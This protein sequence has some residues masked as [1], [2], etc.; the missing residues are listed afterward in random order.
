VQEN[1][2]NEP[3][4]QP[5]TLGSIPTP[6]P[7]PA[8]PPPPAYVAPTPVVGQPKRGF[9]SRIFRSVVL[10]ILILSLVLNG[11]LAILLAE[12]FSEQV[13]LS[14][15]KTQKIA[16][17]DLSGTIDML[18]AA[19]MRRMFKRAEKDEMVKGVI[20][21]VNCPGGQVAPSNMVNRYI[22]DFQRDTGKK[23]YV[24]IQQLGA[25]GAYWISAAA[26]K[27]YAQTNA[28]VGSIGVIYMSFVAENAL[29]EKLGI[30]PLILK[31]SRSPFK[32]RG[33]PF[34]QPSDAEKEKIRK[35]LD[36]VH[37]RFVQVVSEGRG[38]SED[39]AWALADGDVHDGPTALEKKL[40]DAIG[41]LEDVIDDL[42]GELGI[43]DPMV[44]R[45]VT[46]PSV[47]EMLFAQSP[48]SGGILGHVQSQLESWM[49]QPKIQ[50]LWTGK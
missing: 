48:P 5:I 11:Y 36:T 1:D 14:G 31:S 13:Y 28:I 22:Q 40:I 46:P 35:E 4:K 18:T 23:V 43:A 50:V 8:T 2:I 34:R 29:K 49:S 12:R 24:S 32:D 45:Y 6:P 7:P 33:P 37:E 10:S 26:D 21:V 17:I 47:R 15:D 39:E 16:L 20:L 3:E 19:D 44:V 9:L 27:I 38:L 25:S 41:F 42:A 30:D